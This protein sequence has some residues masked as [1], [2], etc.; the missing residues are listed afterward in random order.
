MTR[1][2]SPEELER[3]GEEPSAIRKVVN[4]ILPFGDSP[5]QVRGHGDMLAFL[6]KCC[7]PLPGDEIVGY[8]TR[9]RGVSVHSAECPN[10]RN[11]L[12]HPEREIEVEWARREEGLYEVTLLIEATDQRGVLARLTEAIAKLDSNI[13]HISAET[14]DSPRATI[15]V[16]VEVRNRRHLERLRR[17]VGRLKG[18]ASVTRRMAAEHRALG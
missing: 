5:V 12:Y 6:A 9:G 2:L 13:R 15:E 1:L 10:V 7:M 17:E 16:V 14:R 11:L 18:I 3:A 4:R 8:I